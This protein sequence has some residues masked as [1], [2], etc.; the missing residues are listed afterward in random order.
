MTV[1]WG[2]TNQHVANTA[3]FGYSEAAEIGGIKCRKILAAHEKTDGSGGWI[4]GQ[5]ISLRLMIRF[6]I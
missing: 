6:R 3:W 2:G 4:N 5:R 1:Y